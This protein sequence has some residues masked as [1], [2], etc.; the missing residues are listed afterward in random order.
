M[1]NVKITLREQM[2]LV[3]GWYVKFSDCPHSCCFL[4]RFRKCFLEIHSRRQ[5]D[6]LNESNRPFVMETISIVCTIRKG[7]MSQGDTIPICT[8]PL[9][10]TPIIPLVILTF[11]RVNW[12]HWTLIILCCN[13]VKAA[14]ML[15]QSEPMS[16]LHNHYVV[17]WLYL[18]AIL[19]PLSVLFKN[20]SKC[21]TFLAPVL[22]NFITSGNFYRGNSLGL[23]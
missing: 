11:F 14:S 4:A 17:F 12:K 2:S 15:C 16:T 23:Q 6:K 7:A 19:R 5:A 13:T 9:H 18:T 20:V 22:V 10:W 8:S 3:I 21:K 1:H